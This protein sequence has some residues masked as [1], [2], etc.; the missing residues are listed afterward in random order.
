[1]ALTFEELLVERPDVSLMLQTVI[2]LL[3]HHE[4][5][6][7]N[8]EAESGHHGRHKVETK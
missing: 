6:R 7:S 8:A 1:M 2:M 4:L 3:P 5:Q